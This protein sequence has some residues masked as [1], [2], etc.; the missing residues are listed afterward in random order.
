[1][2]LY[3]GK[4]VLAPMVRVSSVGFRVFCAAQ[5]ADVV[6]SEEVVAAKLGRCRRE[7]RVHNDAV[8]RMIEFVAYE[9]FKN[10]YKRNVV[11]TTP[12]RASANQT[13]EGAP[14]VL[15][16]GV[17]SAAVGAAAALLCC[18][19]VDG[20][21]VNMGCPK[22]FSV[23]NGMGAA[24]MRDTFRAAAILLAMDAAV[25]APDRLT[26]RGRR[27]PLSFKVRLL[28]TS[29]AT[30]DMLIS[31]M[32]KV[33]PNR[34]HA[35][36]LHARTVDQTSETPPHYDRAAETVNRLRSHPLFKEMCFVL[37]GSVRSRED[38]AA[39]MAKFGFD[40]VMLARHAM[41]DMSV[42]SSKVS[43]VGG[44]SALGSEAGELPWAYASWM[45]LYRDLLRCHARY[46][47]PFTFVKYHLTRSISCIPAM[48]HLMVAVQRDANC[49]ADVAR[50]LAMPV[51][52]QASMR[53]A[54]A[55]ELVSCVP[56]GELTLDAATPGNGDVAG[57]ERGQ[58]DEGAAAPMLK[59]R[60][61]Q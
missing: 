59:K 51:E 36:T 13:S 4:T 53:G 48:R 19:D 25:N 11:F 17:S 61:R 56:K 46:C 27:V 38:G 24:L 28:E 9:P 2:S 7:V 30:A 31:I 47:T 15:Q 12:A 21:D 6:F 49:Y 58:G 55:L 20:I 43:S 33:G 10:Q 57:S 23:A 16:L 35:V 50:I 14:V 1:M 26:A 44:H 41:W 22:K 18:E 5:G 32:E 42:F 40:A 54:N 3:Q 29:E 39:K 52:E 34:V 8:G 45:D 37:N 60:K